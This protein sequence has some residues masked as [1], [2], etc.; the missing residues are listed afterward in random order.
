[1]YTQESERGRLHLFIARVVVYTVLIFLSFLCLFC[2]YM[3]I[4]NATRSN[5]Q[6][7]GGFALLPRENFLTNLK[8]A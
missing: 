2:F 8:N 3:L 4:I 1:M 5:A 6:L 7:Q